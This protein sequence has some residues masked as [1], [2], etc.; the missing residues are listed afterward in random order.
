MSPSQKIITD[1]V[2]IIEIKELTPPSVLLEKLEPSKA[3]VDRI[4]KA[5]SEIHRILH[6][7]NDRLL[8]VI[9]PCSIHDYDAGIEYAKRLLTQYHKHS[10][11]LLIVMRVYFEKPRTTV[12][13][14]GLINDPHLN[15]SFDSWDCPQLQNF[16]TPLRRSIRL[17]W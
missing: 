1:D 17:T 10:N 13:W 15:G 6:S 8:V 7:A 16:W 5:R 12:G 11:E 3:T 2:R 9:G 14:K 4:V